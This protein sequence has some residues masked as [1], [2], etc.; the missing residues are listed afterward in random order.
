MACVEDFKSSSGEWVGSYRHEG[1]QIVT[2]S[3]KLWYDVQYR[4]KIGGPYQKAR[5]TYQGCVNYFSGYQ[6]FVDWCQSQ[7]GYMEIDSCGRYWALD[8]DLLND[9]D[10]IG[11]SPKTCCFVPV[12]L[13]GLLQLQ[14]SKRNNFPIGVIKRDRKKKPFSAQINL[15]GKN[16]YLG[17]YKTAQEAHK[18]WQMAKRTKVCEMID[19]YKDLVDSRVI[20]RLISIA[21]L[22]EKD[23]SLNK[24]T[25]KFGG[26]SLAA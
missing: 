1:R 23:F 10:L 21:N 18:A 17:S 5:P 20:D 13:N 3:Y 11:Y 6:P 12:E 15:E 25:V 22:L 4:C 16:K 24:E 7:V 8:K 2:R 14:S 26:V 19:K 9:T